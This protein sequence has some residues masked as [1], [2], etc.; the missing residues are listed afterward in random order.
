MTCALHPAACALFSVSCTLCPVREGKPEALGQCTGGWG[1]RKGS[2]KEQED[3][4]E[5]KV[6]LD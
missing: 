6:R 3:A 1:T 2:L 4:K 5:Q